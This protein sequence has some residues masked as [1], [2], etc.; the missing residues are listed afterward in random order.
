M[1]ANVALVVIGLW[2]VY[3][4]IFAIPAGE[5]TQIEI[6]AEGVAVILL[7]LWARRTDIMRWN[8]GTNIWLAVL[9]LLLAAARYVVALDPLVAFWML[10]LIGIAVAICAMWSILYRPSADQ[11]AGS[12]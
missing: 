7:A 1:I 5:M 9:I 10:L 8:S 12:G 6:M 3:R 2:L 11:T 4:A